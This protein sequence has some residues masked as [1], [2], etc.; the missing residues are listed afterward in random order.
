MRA[1]IDKVVNVWSNGDV[2][3]SSNLPPAARVIGLDEITG[4]TIAWKMSVENGG[5]VVVLGLRWYHAK[6]EHEQMLKTL[7]KGLGLKQKVDCS[8]PN[9]WTSLRTAGARSMLF[10]MNLLSSPMEA[11]VDCRPSWSEGIL[12]TG[13][14]ELGPMSVKTFEIE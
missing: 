14:H 9:V 10:I 4:N 1:T 3:F 12:E 5:Q 13:K 8:N 11:H 7:L 6:R 2:F